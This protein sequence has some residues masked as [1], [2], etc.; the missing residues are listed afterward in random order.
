MKTRS[1]LEPK[2]T[3]ILSTSELSITKVHSIIEYGTTKIFS[4]PMQVSWVPDTLP[5]NPSR[6]ALV[7]CDKIPRFQPRKVEVISSPDWLPHGWVTELK[8]RGSGNSAGSKDKVTT[9]ASFLTILVVK[10]TI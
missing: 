1:T 9:Y 8:T 6:D 4:T 3:K 5:T 7:S 10:A 2:V